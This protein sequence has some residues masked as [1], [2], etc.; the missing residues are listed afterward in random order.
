MLGLNIPDSGTVNILGNPASD[1]ATRRA[2][3]FLAEKTSFYPWLRAREVML[4]HG[5]LCGLG[6]ETLH[7][8][9]KSLLIRVGLDDA[10]DKPV[11][12]YSKG[13][14]Q[15]LGLAQA[16]IDDPEVVILDEPL[17][18]LDPIGRH[19]LREII[20]ELAAEGRTVFFST[21]I[22]SDAELI[23]DRVAV[24]NAGRIV[25]DGDLESL[26]QDEGVAFEVT[27]AAPIPAALHKSAA[28]YGDRRLIARNRAEANLIVDDLRSGGVEITEIRRQ[29][30]S[31]ES[32]F[33][34][35][36]QKG[37]PS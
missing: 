2:I 22:L 24:L 15:R 33:I 34:K 36:I 28:R 25:A 11:G 10:S 5:R 32:Q 18:G 6:S 20:A 4:E 35:W 9:I 27:T 1:P 7:T 17:S 19:Q 14:L 29:Q 13:M 37:E 30:P 3:G 8:R 16:L 31:L 21:H 12:R 23:C 26:Y